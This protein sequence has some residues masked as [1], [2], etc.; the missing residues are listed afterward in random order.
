VIQILQYLTMIVPLKEKLVVKLIFYH[1]LNLIEK[2]NIPKIIVTRDAPKKD[3]SI[4][5]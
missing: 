5:E 2:N 4:S 3:E 1:D